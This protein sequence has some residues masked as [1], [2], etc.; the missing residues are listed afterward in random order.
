[1]AADAPGNPSLAVFTDDE[2][3]IC[4]AVLLGE[5]GDEASPIPDP[6]T[7]HGGLRVREVAIP[8]DLHEEELGPSIFEAYEI[9]EE[10]GE[11]TLRRI[12]NTP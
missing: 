9:S 10:Q 2:G 6:T 12:G 4:G 8:E 1:M 3:N 11:A 5:S 7:A